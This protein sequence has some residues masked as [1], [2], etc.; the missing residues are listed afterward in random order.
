MAANAE[1]TSQDSGSDWQDG[2][3]RDGAWQNGAWKND[4]AA[5][6]GNTQASPE[7]SGSDWQGGDWQDGAWQNSAWQ[8]DSAAHTGNTGVPQRSPTQHRRTVEELTG[9]VEQLKGSVTELKS[10]VDALKGSVTE[11][12]GLLGHVLGPLGPMGQSNGSRNPPHRSHA[13]TPPR[14]PPPR[15]HA[16][17]PLTTPPRSPHPGMVAPTCCRHSACNI[18]ADGSSSLANMYVC[19]GIVIKDLE[20]LGPWTTHLVATLFQKHFDLW[21]TLYKHL[22][23][24]FSNYKISYSTAKANRFF[25]IE[26]HVCGCA[27]FGT[28]SYEKD[29]AITALAC[30]LD[31]ALTPGEIQV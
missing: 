14:T 11:L 25:H 23:A 3:W 20:D 18:P 29:E 21:E 7:V 24:H 1:R 4:R 10:S 2:D 15:S 17:T 28:Y 16:G 31:V 27:V 12:C 30:F 6:T 22:S 5:H 8:N 19:N 13:G 9:S 26:C